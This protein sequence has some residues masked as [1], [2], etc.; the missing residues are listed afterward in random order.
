MNW[1]VELLD[2]RVATEIDGLPKDIRAKILRTFD[3]IETAGLNSL[4]RN[5]VKNV[6]GKIW[7]FRFT[8]KDG[9][10]RI[11]YVTA[12]GRRVVAL[13]AFVKKTQK[14]PK[15]AIDIAEARAKELKP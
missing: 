8:G 9:I 7:E 6:R 3:L 11:L 15:A 14:T 12:S 2:A 1:S 10:A 4:G 13:H 5:L